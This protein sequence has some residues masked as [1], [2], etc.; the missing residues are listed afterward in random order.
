MLNSVMRFN[1]IPSVVLIIPLTL[2]FLSCPGSTV[3]RG[4]MD[5]WPSSGWQ[6][7][8]AEQ[9]GI[10]SQIL[11]SMLENIKEKELEIDSVQ[12]IRNGK[13]VLDTYIH[14]FSKDELHIVHSCAKSVISLLIGIA[15][16][17][18]HLKNLNQRIIKLLPVNEV[19]NIDG[20]KKKI[21]LRHLLTMTTGLNSRDSYL[22]RWEGLSRM[23]ENGDWTGFILDLPMTSKPGEFFEYSNMASFLLSAIITETTGQ[24]ASAYAK[25]NLFRYLGITETIWESDPRGNSVGWGELWLN[26]LDLA[27]IGILVL[28]D[29]RWEDRQIVPTAYLNEATSVQ[30]T[31]GAALPDYG[32]HWWINE[33]NLIMAMGYAGQYLI[34]NRNFNLVTVFTSSLDEKDA[35]IPEQLYSHFI[36]SSISSEG[37]IL[38]NPEASERLRELSR[39]L[40]NPESSGC[41]PPPEAARRING[42]LWVLEPN[43]YG[44]RAVSFQFTSGN[45]EL[46]EYFQDRMIVF[47]LGMDGRFL[48]QEENAVAA[49][50]K[51][52]GDDRLKIIFAGRGAA[53]RQELQ[54]SF[55]ID[56]LHLK[57]HTSDGNSLEIKGVNSPSV[58]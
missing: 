43:P 42:K 53:W 31:T 7:S 56:E 57:F 30:A 34:I 33:D 17:Q 15:L 40:A 55:G 32:Y 22:Y 8:E 46:R 29:G 27:K 48:S 2:L 21:N 25:E 12:I 28:E 45:A 4:N 9:Q 49:S 18:K 41:P 3:Q 14:P 23:R 16:D 52:E 47:P 36:L 37:P 13:L 24:T 58:Y 38:E 19:K 1:L 20:G 26:P 10:D 11:A 51:W 35:R 5:Y 39:Q 44:M 6:K 50:G 54:A